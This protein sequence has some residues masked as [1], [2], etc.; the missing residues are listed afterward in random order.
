MINFIFANKKK[1]LIGEETDEMF[2]LQNNIVFPR[3]IIP[4]TI[5]LKMLFL[6]IFKN[7]FDYIL[8]FL[9]LFFKIQNN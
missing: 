5:W 4:E 1:K 3:I 9:G 6:G 7:M 8:I 2:V